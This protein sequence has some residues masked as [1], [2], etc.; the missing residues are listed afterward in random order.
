M[1][2]SHEFFDWAKT[3]N[4]IHYCVG[5]SGNQVLLKR[6]T[7]LRLQTKAESLY[8]ADKKPVQVFGRLYYKAANW[9]SGQWIF[10]K[11]ECN[12][13]GFNIRF[14]VSSNGCLDPEDTYKRCYCK[15]GDCELYIKELKNGLNADRM[16]CGSF[17]ANQFRLFMYAAAYVLLWYVRKVMFAGTEA[18]SWSIITLRC[19]VILSAVVITAKKTFTRVEFT[20]GHPYKRL[21]E[22]GLFAA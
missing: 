15:R 4:G 11:V 12:N 10:V 17:L 8:M 9:K 21:I 18:E 6:N 20:R 5:I 7:V 16:S 1:F 13:I 14:I 22:I 3:Q 19:R 2:C